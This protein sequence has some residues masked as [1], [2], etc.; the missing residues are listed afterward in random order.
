MRKLFKFQEF[1]NEEFDFQQKQDQILDK[2]S[3]DGIDSLTPSEL[4]FLDAH[5]KGIDDIEKAHTNIMKEE[6]RAEGK[7]ERD[8]F[9]FEVEEVEDYEGDK[10]IYGNLVFDMGRLKDEFYG[11]FTFNPDG[12][13]NYYIFNPLGNAGGIATADD[14][15]YFEDMLSTTRMKDRFEEFSKE[16]YNFFI[17]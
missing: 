13:L 17:N 9:S 11:K 10:N 4:A 3:K 14:E 6:E 8:I 7:F 1:I 15:H 12:T 2:I 5:S 16:L